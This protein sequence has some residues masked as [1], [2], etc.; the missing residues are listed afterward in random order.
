MGDANAQETWA[1]GFLP[2]TCSPQ[3]P[4]LPQAGLATTK[5]SYTDMAQ[6]EILTLTL[7]QSLP[8][9]TFRRICFCLFQ[10]NLGVLPGKLTWWRREGKS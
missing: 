5:H 7:E 2:A 6:T 10:G 8:R 4:S 3:N 9:Q 1:V